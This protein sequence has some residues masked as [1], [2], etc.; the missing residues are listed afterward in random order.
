MMIEVIDVWLIF[1]SH[2]HQDFL[3][4][5]PDFYSGIAVIFNDL[6]SRQQDDV[7][8]FLKSVL[9]SEYTPVEKLEIWNQSGAELFVTPHQIDDFLSKILDTFEAERLRQVRPTDNP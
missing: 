2:I 7:Y 5:F 9:E 1:G 3:M 4:E 8:A 6:S